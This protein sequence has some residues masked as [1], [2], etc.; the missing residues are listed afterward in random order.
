M[1]RGNR[2]IVNEYKNQAIMRETAVNMAYLRVN[3]FY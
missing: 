2:W 3:K 1:R